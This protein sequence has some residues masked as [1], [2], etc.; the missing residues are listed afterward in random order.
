[1]V[2]RRTSP[3]NPSPSLHPHY[4]ASALLRDGPPLCPASLLSPSRFQPLGVLA[5]NGRRDPRSSEPTAAAGRQVHTFRTE[6]RTTLA[7]PPCRTPPGQ[8]AGTRQARPGAPKHPRFRCHLSLST[9]HQWFACAHLRDPHLPRLGATFPRRS[10]PRLLTAAARGG[11][12]PPP[13]RR[14]RRATRPT[15]PWP[16]HLLHSTASGDLVFYIQPPS[17]FVF[18]PVDE[19]Q[20][21]G[22]G[23]FRCLFGQGEA[24]VAHDRSAL[25]EV[26]QSERTSLGRRYAGI[27][28]RRL[29]RS[30][31]RGRVSVSHGCDGWCGSSSR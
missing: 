13:A 8:S 27:Q 20:V 23:V 12:R 26:V 1:M 10:P 18:T 4:R 29:L 31:L 24:G 17:T 6:A 5:A 14:P 22:T 11:L 2:D 25:S 7:P 15:T 28:E 16:L 30:C 3:D 9:R 19:H 21:R